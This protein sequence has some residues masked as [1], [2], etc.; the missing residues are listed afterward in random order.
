MSKGELVVLVIASIILAIRLLL[1]FNTPKSYING[2]RIRINSKLVTEPIRYSDAQYI[3]LKGLRIYLPIYPEVNYGDS[4]V[5]EGVVDGNR[6][7]DVVLV[8]IKENKGILFSLRRRLLDVYNRSLPKVDASL[9]SGVAIGSK[10]SIPRN[11]WESLKKSG[12]AHVVVASG[13]NVALV[14]GFLMSL[15]VGVFPRRQAIPLVFVG[16]WLYS[17]ISGFDAP[18]VRAALMGSIALTAQEF[19]RLYLASRALIVCAIVMLLYKPEWLTDLGFILSF[20]ATFSLILF[21]R[22]I[23]RKIRYV[24]SIFREGLST[25]LAAQIGVAPILFY[26]FGQFNLLSPVI[27][28]AVL[29]TIAPITIIGLAGGIIGLLY[30]PLGK[31]VLLIGYPLT[32]WFV[33]IVKHTG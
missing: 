32:S 4:V 5:I 17:L 22:V 15:L 10:A 9:I 2:D 7:S 33:F 28:A 8:D 29:W 27:N 1:F 25:S 31:L 20:L 30:F 21:E 24:P 3:K 16:I 12:T 11:F 23:N 6:L 18:I 19:G 26:T 13:M 14:A